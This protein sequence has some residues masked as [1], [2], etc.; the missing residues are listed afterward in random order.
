MLGASI[1]D[2]GYYNDWSDLFNYTDQKT[3]DAS[4]ELPIPDKKTRT[5]NEEL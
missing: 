2:S 5:L 4:N 1:S 3:V